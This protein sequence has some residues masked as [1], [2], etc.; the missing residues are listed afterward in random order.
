MRKYFVQRALPSLLLAL[1]VGCENEGER[2]VDHVL[3]DAPV[4][5]VED[6]LL[7]LEQD[8]QGEPSALVLDVASEDA[9]VEHHE[10]PAGAPQSF[11]R[12][13]SNGRE[14]IVF[15]SG[16]VGDR[17]AKDERSE[18]VP[19]HLSILDRTGV[20][21]QHPLSSVYAKLSLSEDGKYAL[22]QQ[23]SG[24][25]V[26]GNAL[27]VIDLDKVPLQG[28]Q[29]PS[30]SR[31]VQL[32][33][34]GRE[35]DRLVFSPKG[36]FTRRLAIA[37]L[38][39]ALQV[40]ELERP[41]LPEIAIKLDDAGTFTPGEIVFAGD[42]FFVQGTGSPRILA[43]QY[44]A[45][46]RGQHDFQLA[47]TNLLASGGPVTD[48]AVTG[49]G[50]ALRVLALSSAALDVIDPKVNATTKIDAARGFTQ[51][52]QFEARSP[53]DSNVGPRA[54]LYSQGRAQIGFV[55]LA[56]ESA[57]ASRSVEL[58]ELGLPLVSLE[59]I[60]SKNLALV[61]HAA[62]RLSVVDLAARTVR[63]FLLDSTSNETL[64]DES[65]TAA[66]I[67]VATG[68]GSLG[69]LDLT[70]SRATPIPLT[71]DRFA[72]GASA[73]TVTANN[74][75]VLVPRAGSNA[76]RIAV[77]QRSETGRVTFLDAD[78]PTP[79][80]ALEVLGFLLAGLFD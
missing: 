24:L 70:S 50:D 47:P 65:D 10:L 72:G 80:T 43:F 36:G 1:S 3:I 48:L 62:D 42:Q 56:N 44:I 16:R 58:I 77:L 78:N 60:A 38:A 23:A 35:V 69:S 40:I 57:W 6:G 15:T 7:F 4:R 45:V 19:A 74:N 12:P 46:P 34:D 11:V 75:L 52:V 61:R 5:S 21:R 37:P 49:T 9:R 79:D 17:S 51:L 54:A 63:P 55:D 20:V 67:W 27:E 53:V 66:R 59:L 26:A 22:A 73:D 32:S 28:A 13:G 68:N 2:Q 31:P 25:L 8:E 71:F 18:T 41:D 14:V 33:F 30:A 64:L 76:R 29:D 39:D